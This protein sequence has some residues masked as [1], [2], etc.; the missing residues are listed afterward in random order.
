LKVAVINPFDPLPGETIREARYAAFC[1]ALARAGHQ[2]IWYSSDWSHAFKRPR[3]VDAVTS[4]CRKAGIAVELIASIPYRKNVSLARLRSHEALTQDICGRLR[5]TRP[6]PRAILVS[7]PPPVLAAEVAALAAK[8]D[9]KV[10][11]DVQ[12]LWPETFR[13]VWPTGLRWLHRAMTYPIA[14]DMRRAERL[15]DAGIGVADA[16]L[17]RFRKYA[18]PGVPV[19]TLHLGVDLAEFDRHTT[20]GC[21]SLELGEA[22]RK[23]WVLVGGT[24][25]AGLD[26]LFMLELA[27]LLQA[28]R[29]DIHLL[30]AGTG[31]LEGFVRRQVAARGLDNVHPL[32]FQPYPVFCRLAARADFGLNHCRA[33]SF[34]YFP[35]RVFDYLA[36]DLRVINTVGGELAE[37][38]AAHQAGFTTETFDA[39]A[40]VGYI[41]QV[42]DERPDI[43]DRHPPCQRRGVWVDAFDRPKIARQ[44]V[45]ILEELEGG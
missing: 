33:D 28:R 14:R 45:R 44:L 5:A 37:L 19:H 43:D 17:R 12:D 9:A 34:V 2:V 36:A 8:R 40:A 30:I 1:R 25:T 26:W 4:A 16:Y 24:M 15:A 6:F 38:L 13:R 10:V 41:E 42:M 31:A 23:R 32:G 29:E 3:D 18:R 7:A 11:L 22:A 35:N 21:P 27:T 20:G 39:A